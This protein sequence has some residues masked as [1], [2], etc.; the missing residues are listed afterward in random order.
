[1][2]RRVADCHQCG[3]RGIVSRMQDFLSSEHLDSATG[4]KAFSPGTNLRVLY[5]PTGW[6]TRPG[7]HLDQVHRAHR[8]ASLADLAVLSIHV[9]DPVQLQV[10]HDLG[11]VGGASS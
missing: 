5:D 4:V 10:L 9:V 8:S 11:A 3:S 6:W 7:L 1:M 2:A